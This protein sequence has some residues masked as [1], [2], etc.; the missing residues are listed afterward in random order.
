MPFLLLKHHLN[1]FCKNKI[2]LQLRSWKILEKFDGL[3]R[4]V[5]L[6]QVIEKFSLHK[7]AFRML[8]SYIEF[9]L[10]VEENGLIDNFVNRLDPA[11]WTLSGSRLCIRIVHTI[12]LVPP[13]QVKPGEVAPLIVH[14]AH[15]FKVLHRQPNFYLKC[16]D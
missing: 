6:E 7:H 15:H 5:N 13:R 11:T 3:A 4:C 1:V 2:F 8:T 12:C 14:T 10:F 16:Y 9:P